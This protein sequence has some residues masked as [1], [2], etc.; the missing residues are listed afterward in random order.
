[1]QF[2]RWPWRIKVGSFHANSPGSWTTP[3][4]FTRMLLKW[5]LLIKNE[6]L[7]SRFAMEWSLVPPR[8][9]SN[10]T[11]K[12]NFSTFS[13]FFDNISDVFQ[14]ILFLKV[15]LCS[16]H[17][18]EQFVFCLFFKSNISF[19]TILRR[20]TSLNAKFDINCKPRTSDF[21]VRGR[22]MFQKVLETTPNMR[23]FACPFLV[24]PN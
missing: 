15:A 20:K 17:S 8:T 3:S 6:G 12:L 7:P 23:G 19:L 9:R 24:S 16:G 11:Q 22:K 14:P 2:A 5:L 1:M 4:D 10:F 18:N 13:P 21:H